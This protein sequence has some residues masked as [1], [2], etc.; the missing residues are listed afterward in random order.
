VSKAEPELASASA[1]GRG[2]GAVARGAGRAPRDLGV[3]D[4]G[5][6]ARD[7]E[8]S[9][10]AGQGSRWEGVVSPWMIGGRSG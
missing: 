6:G 7:L 4:S 5:G 3:D 8:R 1:D 9:Q 10:V 2:G